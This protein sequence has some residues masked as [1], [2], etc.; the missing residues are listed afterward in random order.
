MILNRYRE[1]SVEDMNI[2]EK[3]IYGD[4]QEKRRQDELGNWDAHNY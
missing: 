3:L 2:L 4:N 1:N